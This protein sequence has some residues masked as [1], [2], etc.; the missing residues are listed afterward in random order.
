MTREEKLEWLAKV[1]ER[2][3]RLRLRKDVYQPNPGQLP[4]HLCQAKIRLVISGN[5]AGKTT[6]GVQE[7]MWSADGYNPVSD[8]FIS[9][10]RRVV[11]VLD[12]PDKVADKWLPEIRKWFHIKEGELKKN[13]KPYINQ[14]DRPSGS[15]VKF[16]FHDQDPLTFESLE[17][18]DVIFDEPPPR[19]VY[20]ALLR[21]TRNK[22]KKQRI[23]IIGTPITG[24]WLRKE[25]YE[26]WA[27]GDLDDTECFKFSSHVNDANVPEGFVDW[28]SSKLSEK[29][30]RIRIDGEFFDLDGLALA[31]LF[32]QETHVIPLSGFSWDPE[33]PVVVAIDPH[34]GKPHVALMVGADP[35]GPVVLKELS[36]KMTPRK[37]AKELKKWYQGYRITDIVCDDLGSAEMTGGEDFKSFIDIL[38][39]EGIMVRA[40]RWEDKHDEDW[41]TRIQDALDIPDEPD[42]FG[43]QIPALRVLAGNKGTVNDIE[44]VEWDKYR[45]LDEFKPSLA[46]GA[47]DFLACLKYALATNLH[48]G[49]RKEKAYYRNKPAYGVT[50]RH[51]TQ[52][53]RQVK[54]GMNRARKKYLKWT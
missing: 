9:V 3:R 54:M 8:T 49:K 4:V 15:E 12:K 20:I 6:M 48:V 21:G 25:I 36:A 45:N 11:V 43:R 30:R 50:P 28:F 5:G 10:P 38:K 14:I 23:M 44:T 47:K 33:W 18:D 26:P 16:M 27:R 13:G 51:Q 53:R 35:F 24:S 52:A 37:F 46:I 1:D 7:A 34:P 2:E 39:E 32:R 40:T 17:A 42:Q 41:V 31:H 19:H 29:E 22:N